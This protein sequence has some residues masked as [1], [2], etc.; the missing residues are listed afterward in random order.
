MPIAMLLKGGAERCP[1]ESQE[2]TVLYSIKSP[3]HRAALKN[4]L[5]FLSSIEIQDTDH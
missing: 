5:V 3:V 4:E 1:L 2:E